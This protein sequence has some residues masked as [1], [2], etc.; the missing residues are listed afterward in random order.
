MFTNREYYQ[1]HEK[2][3]F[4]GPAGQQKL[5]GARVLVIGAG[6]L[7]CPCLLYLATSG[8]G[9]IGIADLDRVSISNLHRQVLY[10][11]ADEGRLKVTAAAARLRAHNPDITLQE[12]PV[13]VNESNILQMLAGYQLVVDCTDNFEV[14]YLINDACVYTGIP[15][16]YGAIYQAEGQVTVFNY[17][18]SGTLRCL[19]PEPAPGL[20]ASCADI[21]AFNICT[22]VTGSLMAAEALKVILG[23]PEV[24]AGRLVYIDTLSASARNLKYTLLAKNK[25]I[26][27][28]RFLKQDDAVSVSPEAFFNDPQYRDYTLADVREEHERERFDIGGIHI[29]LDRL[30][31]GHLEGLSAADRIIFYCQQGIRSRQAADF[32]R[33]RGYR[34][35]SIAGGL[36][37]CTEYF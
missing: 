28:N 8:I 1:S 12:Y 33:S 3:S 10:T 14:R 37:A 27:R 4:I 18:G 16:V 5:A 36:R 17:Q 20:I 35:Y 21:G 26:S 24:A 9:H 25:E 6:G 19:F 13:L 31:A 32:L 7:G 11:P 2:L 29:P 34:A 30:L 23:H 22:S 15:L